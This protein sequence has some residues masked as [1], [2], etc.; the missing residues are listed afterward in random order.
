LQTPHG[1][2]EALALTV[3]RCAPVIA[4]AS[5]ERL[6]LL[7]GWQLRQQERMTDADFVAIEGIPER[8]I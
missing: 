3:A 6:F 2:K 5:R 8:S 7:V 4:E 1:Q